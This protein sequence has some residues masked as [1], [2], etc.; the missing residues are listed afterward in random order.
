MR[1]LL[2]VPLSGRDSYAQKG[3]LLLSL[4]SILRCH[5]NFIRE[6]LLLQAKVTDRE[7]SES[8]KQVRIHH[9]LGGA[10]ETRFIMPPS[11]LSSSHWQ[12]V[13]KNGVLVWGPN[14]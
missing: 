7:R 8:R 9:F 6:I 13:L 5:A 14:D 1:Y 2:L 3:S 4:R 11:I 10:D 12:W